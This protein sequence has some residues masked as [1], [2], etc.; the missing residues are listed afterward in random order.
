MGSDLFRR[1]VLN[2]RKQSWLGS[3]HLSTTRLAW[4]M[5]I[6]AAMAIA[7]LLLVLV[8]GTHTRK[9]RVQG[10]LLPVGGLQTVVAP[11]PGML[12]RRLVDEGQHVQRHQPLLEIST[13]I[14][15]PQGDGAIAERVA[16]ALEQQSKRLREDLADLETMEQ[17]RAEAL[18]AQVASIREQLI[19]ADSELQLRSRQA[20]AATRTLDRI[21]P[22]REEKIVSDVQIQQYE[23]QALDAQAQRESTGRNLL[24]LERQLSE[25]EQDLDELPLQTSERR[26]EI[27]RALADVSRSTTLNQAQH[28]ILIRA[29]GAGTVSG[30]VVDEGQAVSERQRL[31]SIVPEDMLLRAELWV[32]SRAI[33]TLRTGDRVAM[34]Y[35][36]F[37]FQAF[38]QQYGHVSAIGGSAL[39]PDE[40]L[41]RTGT[42]PGEPVYRVM[43]ALD[44]QDVAS[45]SDAF[46][47]RPHMLLDADLLLERRRLYQLVLEPF[48]KVRAGGGAADGTE[49]P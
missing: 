32:P 40:V 16:A 20:E 28:K 6:L 31:L 9:Q 49:V 14:D 19:A 29:P 17:Q 22:L 13:G 46:A 48:Q 27:E 37:P 39:P 35:E 5:A 15:T 4:P 2:A 44:R 30:L 33:G 45:G 3:V 8:L 34:R 18:A 26:S 36:A 42:D 25:A 41:A 10:Q 21:R 1:E 47:L 11:V 12:T 23:N 7:T 24:D 38:G 43:V